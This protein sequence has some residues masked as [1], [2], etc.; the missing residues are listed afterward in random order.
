M[1]ESTR[2]TPTGICFFFFGDRVGLFNG[3]G[4]YSLPGIFPGRLVT[5]FDGP[6]VSVIG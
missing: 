1:M 3:G 4:Y 5:R 2:S 6:E